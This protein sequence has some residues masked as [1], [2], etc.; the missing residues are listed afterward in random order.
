MPSLPA[1]PGVIKIEVLQT[2]AGQPC[3]NVMHAMSRSELQPSADQLQDACGAA[4]LAWQDGFLPNQ[5]ADITLVALRMTDLTNLVGAQ[6]ISPSGE[7]GAQ[8]GP[9]SDAA[10]ALCI[11]IRS[12]MRTRSGRG[13]LYLG[14]VADEHVADPRHWDAEFAAGMADALRTW[15]NSLTVAD[16]VAGWAMDLGVLSYFSGVDEAGR[17]IPRAEPLF[18]AATGFDADS[19]IDTQRRRLG[20]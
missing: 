3:V 14:G 12:A 5:S 1:A 9:V 19:R 10:R 8:T 20:R 11:T 16:P 2:M 4:T 15:A 7:A 6:V 17:P 13:R 18:N